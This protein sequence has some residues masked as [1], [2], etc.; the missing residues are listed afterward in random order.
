L[1]CFTRLE[2]AA[3]PAWACTRTQNEI[4]CHSY[5]ERAAARSMFRQKEVL[6]KREGFAQSQTRDTRALRG[7]SNGARQAQLM[8]STPGRRPRLHDGPRCT[9]AS[10]QRCVSCPLVQRHRHSPARAAEGT[11]LS[12]WRGGAGAHPRPRPRP[13]PLPRPRP[14]PAAAVDVTRFCTSLGVSST[15]SVSRLTLSGRM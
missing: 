8:T 3:H 11:F 15:S 2:L 10:R 14:R 5:F 7:V 4:C 6:H 13:L 1:G 12:L 9:P